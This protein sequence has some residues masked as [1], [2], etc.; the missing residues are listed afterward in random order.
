[1][2]SLA[3]KQ[4]IFEDAEIDGLPVKP[5]RTELNFGAQ[6]R[7]TLSGPGIGSRI[8]QLIR[9]ENE[10]P[11][12]GFTTSVHSNAKVDTHSFVRTTAQTRSKLD[13]MLNL[14]KQP[15]PLFFTSTFSPIQE[16]EGYVRSMSEE[17][18]IA[19]LVDMA[20]QEKGI[21]EQAEIPLE[22][23]TDADRQK[24]R[25]GSIFRWSIGYQRTPSGT[26]MRVSNIVFRDLPR[27]TQKD[28]REAGEEAAKL[29]EYFNLGRQTL[30]SSIEGS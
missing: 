27:W 14:P 28:I 24:M 23:I 15:V 2:N 26:K 6:Q 7:P 10:A 13:A 8:K 16:W 21:T 9:D 22:E 19:D 17:S 18:L 25:L 5:V 20:H 30:P 29:E 11:N 3:L 4:S 12:F 1:M